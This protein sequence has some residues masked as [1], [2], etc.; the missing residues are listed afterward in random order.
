MD[1]M[2]FSV[3]GI[4]PDGEFE[5]WS[6][7]YSE[8]SNRVEH[9]EVDYWMFMANVHKKTGYRPIPSTFKMEYI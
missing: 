6:A 8:S 1:K 7:I 9:D 4:N 3:S 5:T 2:R